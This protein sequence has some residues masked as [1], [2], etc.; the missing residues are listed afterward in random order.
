MK[1]LSKR[2]VLTCG[3]ALAGLAFAAPGFA[4]EQA[5]APQPAPAGISQ[6]AGLN[7]GDAIVVTGSRIRRGGFDSPVPVTVVDAGLVEDLGQVNASEVVRLIPQNIAT[8]SDAV[9]GLRFSADIGAAYANLRGLNPQFGTRTLTLVNTRRFVPTS[10]GG[11]VDLN[12]IPSIMIGRVETVTGGASAA[13]GSDAVAGVVNII[14]DNQ[15][16]GFK[17]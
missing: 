8:Q 9:A 12:L 11:Q 7:A 4:Q 13:Y 6:D 5:P 3:S 16:D 10:D 1:L 17:G 15:L 2:T 14:L